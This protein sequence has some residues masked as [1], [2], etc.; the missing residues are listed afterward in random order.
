MPKQHSFT[1]IIVDGSAY[2]YRAFHASEKAN[3]RSSTGIPTGAVHVMLNMLSVLSKQYPQACI[4]V[5]FDAPGK[6]FRHQIFSE[7]KANRSSM[8]EE[9]KQ[10]VPYIKDAIK[11]LGMP[12][13]SLDNMEADDVIGVLAKQSSELKQ[14]L[15]ICTGDKDF[16]QLVNK[17]VFLLDTMKDTFLDVQ[18]VIDK[19]S[20]PPELIIDYLALMGD[21]SDNIPGVPGVGEKTALALLQHIG[22]TDEILDNLDKIAQLKVR[23]S[24]TLATKIEQNIDT[25]KISKELA[26]IRTDLDIG[27][28]VTD[29]KMQTKNVKLLEEL[30]QKLGI[31]K[32]L[33]FIGDSAS[34]KTKAK[35]TNYYYIN[36]KKDFTAFIAKIKQAKIFAVDTETTS[37]NTNKAELVGISLCYKEYDAVYIPVKHVATEV[38]QLECDWVIEQLKPIL[39]S[40]NYTKIMQ[41]AKYDINIFYKYGINITTNFIDTM[42]E[43]YVLN[44]TITK[45]NMND[46]ALRY[47]DHTAISYQQITGSGKKQ[48]TFDQVAI[49]DATEYAAEDAD[50]TLRLHNIFKQQLAQENKL[51]S[52]LDEVELPL[53]TILAAMERTGVAIDTAALQ[54]QSEDLAVKLDNIQQTIY[55][56]AGKEFNIL[57]TKQLQEVLFTELQLPVTKKTAS[58]KPSTSEEALQELSLGYAIAQEIMNY[59]SI[60]KLKTAY[61][62]KLPLMVDSNTNRLHTTYHQAVT[63]TGRLSSADPNIQNIPIKTP[64]GKLVRNAF[65][66]KQGYKIMAADYS[67][68]E[69]RIMAHL[70]QDPGLI[71]AFKNNLDVHKITASEIF[72]IAVADVTEDQR[73]KAKT[74]NFGLIYGMSAFGLAKQ[75]DVSLHA[76]NQ[77]INSYF[78]KYP[79]VKQYMEQAKTFAKEH[80]YVETI[81]GRK[82]YLPHINSSNAILRNAAERIA[83]NAPMQGSAADIIKKAMYRIYQAIQQ[84]KY[85]ATMLM[86]VHD[87]LVFEVEDKHVNKMQLEINKQMIAEDKLSVPLVVDIGCADNWGLAH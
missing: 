66:A 47:L 15:L 25:L 41:N 45:H 55:T 9:L 50:I 21:K 84:H 16:A 63:S 1:K 69:L 58:G 13:L 64:Q 86:Q 34:S 74:I 81:Y 83:I 44:S 8:P 46:M 62:D 68:V 67:Q 4:A 65:I 14:D 18:G 35:A 20:L 28:S 56:I 53:V 85:S 29:L 26:T 59:R 76:A 31:K 17:Y 82:L 23:G 36:T 39:E 32:L 22:S 27:I 70:S 79:T 10:Q 77:Y 12:L 42:L 61:T 24:K 57:S 33:E 87:E 75:L 80:G 72:D 49:E 5:V 78:S 51:K 48:I 11:A 2:L 60:Y 38:K 71:K 37:L 73:R 19:F 6:N 54:K 7:Y 43:S 52:L 30:H 3:L 40:S